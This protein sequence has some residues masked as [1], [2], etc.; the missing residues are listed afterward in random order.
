MTHK[1]TTKCKKGAT[2]THTQKRPQKVTVQSVSCSLVGVGVL[3]CFSVIHYLII[4]LLL[5]VTIQLSVSEELAVHANTS[6]HAKTSAHTQ[7]F[8][9]QM[10]C[11]SKR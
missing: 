8:I 9:L 1:M 6:V 7:K 5:A 3:P 4:S 10:A 11:C 2:N